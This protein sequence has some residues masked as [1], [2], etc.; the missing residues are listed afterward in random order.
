MARF[1]ANTGDDSDS[2]SDGDTQILIE[3]EY[4]YPDVPE[5][6]EEE[7]EEEEEEEGESESDADSSPSAS[8]TSSESDLH[9]DDLLPSPSRR[10]QPT[11]NAL[12]HDDDDGEIHYA[13][14]V[15]GLNQSSA[16]QPSA[17]LRAD[18]SVI[19][20]ARQVGVD[21]QKMHVMQTSFFRV[22]EEAAALS[23]MNQPQ[24]PHRVVHPVLHRKH[25]RDSEGDV[26]RIDSREVRCGVRWASMFGSSLDFFFCFVYF[27]SGGSDGL[28][29]FTQRPSFAHDI[30]P[31]AYRPSRKYARIESSASAVTG[32]ER[33]VVD[34]GLAMGRSFRPSWGPSGTLVHLGEIC[35]PSTTP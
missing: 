26:L 11:R 14:E 2:D 3:N 19:P 29:F 28:V 21:A 31:P 30:D 8:L 7:E 16:P 9:E 35:S 23:A 6:I 27:A 4:Q 15:N 24:R 17:R 22:P 25:S 1:S 20:W 18:P 13:H 12:I 5:P 34:A 10:K 32:H 33:C